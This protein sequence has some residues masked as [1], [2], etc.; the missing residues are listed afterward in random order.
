MGPGVNAGYPLRGVGSVNERPIS[1]RHSVGRTTTSLERPVES[2]HTDICS[3][4]RIP[5]Q[6]IEL[7]VVSIKSL[8][9]YYWIVDRR[10]IILVTSL[11][12]KSIS[13]LNQKRVMNS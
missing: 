2:I 11:H 7:L 4:I 8:S 10:A 12:K 5:S 13:W 6:T 1:P 3:T 9:V